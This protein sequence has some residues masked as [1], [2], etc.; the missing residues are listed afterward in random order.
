MYKESNPDTEDKV[1]RRKKRG[2]V[3][4]IKYVEIST[5]LNGKSNHHK[6][7]KNKKIKNVH[8]KSYENDSWTFL[9]PGGLKIN[10]Y[11]IWTSSQ[12]PL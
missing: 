5:I 9:S 6:S 7:K 12:T 4:V 11:E 1:I 8:L 2:S 10:L 3:T